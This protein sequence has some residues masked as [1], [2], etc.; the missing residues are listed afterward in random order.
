MQRFGCQAYM[1]TT[2]WN[3]DMKSS[4]FGQGGYDL[5]MQVNLL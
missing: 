3:H 4:K 2:M 1:G 5:A